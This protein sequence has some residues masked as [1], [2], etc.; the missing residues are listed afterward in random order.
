MF[1][2]TEDLSSIFAFKFN[3]EVGLLF[4]DIGKVH[5]FFFFFPPPESGKDSIEPRH[6]VHLERFLNE[7]RYQTLT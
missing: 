7:R 4:R 2:M 5:A 3:F 1:S 6:S